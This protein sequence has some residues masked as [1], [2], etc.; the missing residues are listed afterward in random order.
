MH[1]GIG[2]GRRVDAVPPDAMA[3]IWSVT[4][5]EQMVSVVH[6]R[7]CTDMHKRVYA[8]TNT[9]THTREGN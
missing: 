2:A 3:Q 4:H 1:G 9:H 5:C 7:T 8:H 6:A